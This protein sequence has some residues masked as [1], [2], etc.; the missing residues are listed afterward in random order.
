MSSVMRGTRGCQKTTRGENLAPGKG[1]GL[2]GTLSDG[3]GTRINPFQ[4]AAEHPRSGRPSG[5]S[6]TF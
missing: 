4:S 3:A 6:R 2:L 1:S 5:R